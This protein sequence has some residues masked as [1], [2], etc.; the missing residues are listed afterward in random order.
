MTHP[1]TVAMAAGIRTVLATQA[2]TG[3]QARLYSQRLRRDMG[4]DGL[5]SFSGGDVVGLLDEAMLLLESG[6]LER[7]A[8]LAS[9]WRTAIKR[10]AEILE[11]LS[12]PD[13]RPK[14]AP[15]HLLAAAAYQ[16]ADFPA[17]AIGHLR[18]L[19]AEEPLSE[20]LQNFLRADFPATF[21]ATQSFWN[22]RQSASHRSGDAPDLENATVQHIIMC[23]GTICAHL[24]MG[25]D[26][27][28]ERAI[29]KLERLAVSYLHSRDPFSYL[30]ARLTAASA[31]RFVETSMWPQIEQLRFVSSAAAGAALT[32][33]ARSAYINRRALVWPAQAVG[34]ERLREN[35]SFV[36][37]TPTGSGKTTVATLGAVQGLFADSGAGVTNP[38]T[39]G[40]LVLYLVPSRALAAEVEGRLTEDLRGISASPVVVTG[41]Y[42]GVDWGPTDAWVQ[43]DQPTV[44]ICTFEKADAL[45]RYLGV[46]FLARVR[47]VIIDEAHM[48]DQDTTRLAGLQDGSSRSFRL[49]QLGSRL[50]RA[51]SQ[52]D[53]RIVALS[54]VAARAAP[55]LARWITGSPDAEP[56]ASSYRSTRQ[57]L[58]RLEV[59]D[60]GQC[61]IRYDL[62]DG[63]SLKFEDMT[64][65]DTPFVSDPFPPSPPG[66]EGDDGPELRMRAPTLWAAL[67]LA[68]RRPD[69]ST[70]SVLISLTQ[71][72][73]G[74]AKTCVELMDAWRDWPLP[75]YRAVNLEDGAW[76]RCLAAAA[77]YFSVNSVEYRLLAHGIAL[78]HGK[79]PSLLA[80][81]LKT[82]IDRGYIRVI[83][84]TSTLSEGVNIPVNY[85]LIPSV[86]RADTLLPLQ[87][88]SNLIGRA[89]RPGVATEGNAL[90][91]LP[92][93]TT[94]TN[95]YG[96]T[97]YSYSRQ[98]NGYEQLIRDLES[99]TNAAVSLVPD[100]QASSP[101]R[102]L[103]DA[104]R[105]AWIALTGGESEDEFLSW[106]DQTAVEATEFSEIPLAHEYL[107]SL[108]AF[109]I[110]SI[111][112]I[113]DLLSIELVGPALET[114]LTTI[115]RR[116]YAFAA[117]RGEAQLAAV[118]LA[119][120]RA[121]KRHYPEVGERRRLYRTSLSPRSGRILLNRAEAVRT[122]LGEGKDYAR[123]SAEQ[124]LSYAQGVL[125]LLS[126]VPSFEIKRTLGRK[127]NFDDW[128]KILRWWLAKATLSRQPKPTEITNWFSF[129]AENFIYRGSWGL[130]SVI[131]L[132]LDS[133]D[134]RQPIRALEIADWPR[135]GLPWIAFWLKELI[136]WG[137]LDPVA[138]F[139]LARGDALDRP[140]AESDAKHYYQAR[141]EETDA[142][143]LLD[144]T[145]IRD[146]VDARAPVR[147]AR[148]P[149]H[150]ATVEVALVR[151]SADFR[152][153]RLAVSPLANAAALTWI[154]PAGYEVAR[155]AKPVGWDDDLSRYQFELDVASATVSGEPYQLHL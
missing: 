108:D 84:A 57:M 47:T 128:P 134:G 35:T 107:D 109:L 110:A 100:D 123:W 87:E 7:S 37:C 119:R 70:P 98:W 90:V 97:V 3:S 125:A 83:I 132:L 21:E 6:W 113:E 9:P 38:P 102:H 22:T 62:M 44:V 131:G 126:E 25:S 155:S 94:E 153:A 41:L 42:G 86:Y 48:V 133:S 96:Q 12:Q 77:D 51:R 18:L 5:A 43:T 124:Q 145:A 49:E 116:T 54:A 17:M 10:A 120:G 136:G 106:L 46:L 75:A 114:E 79:M 71:N 53:F 118:W 20:L 78:H 148:S 58:G 121:I 69:G 142:N 112:E 56:I 4:R 115:W 8:D 16:L 74:F 45:L 88:F 27:P 19:P 67:N 135:T 127:K 80:R 72:A 151:P 55:A 29:I 89:G 146:W 143:A 117:S 64:R 34:I 147:F 68:A 130:G 1:A 13:L 154:D 23:V 150:I 26:V 31:R 60:A 24:R 85:L 32:Q 11:W 139:L 14:G 93:R 152:R 61:T 95:R 129:V 103:L 59:S 105:T 99:A 28:V 50:M 92:R 82:V 65:A 73:S 140:Q 15:L 52:F 63:R 40:N 141:A 76:I 81:R 144:P 39:L 30:L 101:L 138:A 149:Q 2:L 33:F 91:V 36:L 122:K 137:T 104:L 111:Q 66:L